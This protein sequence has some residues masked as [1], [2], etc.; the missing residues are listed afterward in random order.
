MQQGH[1][2]IESA[3]TTVLVEQHPDKRGNPSSIS[4]C[5]A[6]ASNTATIRLF[7]DDGTDQVS[8]VENL[9]IPAG[10]TLFINDGL[11]YNNTTQSLQLQVAGTSPDIKVIVI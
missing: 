4:I 10:V 9:V 8:M 2:K 7:L 3:S 6:S 1:F 11:S 5:N